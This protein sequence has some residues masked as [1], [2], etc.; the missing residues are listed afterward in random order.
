MN[1][2]SVHGQFATTNDFFVSVETVMM[3]RAAIQQAG[4]ELYCHRNLAHAQVTA[5]LRARTRNDGKTADS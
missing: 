5:E 1:E 4:R 3:I 2:L